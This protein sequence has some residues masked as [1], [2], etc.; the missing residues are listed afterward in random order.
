[1]TLVV[2]RPLPG[3]SYSV[4]GVDAQQ[5]PTPLPS[6]NIASFTPTAPITVMGGETLGLYSTSGGD[7]CYWKGAATPAADTPIT[8]TDTVPAGLTIDS[9]MAGTGGCAITA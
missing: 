9:A 7:L 2:L 6:G 3:A 4:V 8:L 5:L 1:M